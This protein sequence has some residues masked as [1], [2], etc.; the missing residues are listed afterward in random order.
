MSS[1]LRCP[2]VYIAGDKTVWGVFKQ[3]LDAA[4]R[5]IEEHPR[6][7]LFRR[8]IE[9][10]PHHPDD[11][12]SLTSNGESTLSD[13]ECGMWVQFIYSHMVNRFK[14]ELA[15]LL[16]I[17][18]CLKLI[19]K[20]LNEGILPGGIKLY[21]GDMIQQRRRTRV[22][23]GRSNAQWGSF[24]KGAD[25]LI[26]EQ[27]SSLNDNYKHK[28]NIHGVIE[29]KSMSLSTKK[30]LAQIKNHISRLNGGLKLGGIIWLPYQIS[31]SRILHIIVVPSTWKLSREWHSAKKEQ[32]R[33][34]MLPE[35]SKPPIGTHVEKLQLDL[36]KIRLAWS[37]EAL[38]QAAYEMTFWYMSQVGKHI[39]AKKRLPKE[40]EKMTPEEAGYNSIKM[41][42]YYFPLRYLPERQA[43]L[44]IKLYN[45]Y[46]F[47]YPLGTDSKDILWPEDFPD[48]IPEKR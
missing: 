30:V 38:N 36:W 35:P 45:V 20:L 23:D 1:A 6:G 22:A 8:L 15:E 17:E 29:V 5:D 3:S 11:P 9:Y 14:G 24:C 2:F 28:L 40:W 46:S 42:L 16:S 4:I 47:G 10:G 32:R 37:Q 43:R 19:N 48:H 33:E 34:I 12:K 44:A 21:L 18:P 7:K 27:I 41:M 13:T 39:Y 25:G 31:F 26:V